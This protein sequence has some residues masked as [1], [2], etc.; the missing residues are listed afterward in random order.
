MNAFD[1][2]QEFDERTKKR[3]KN[4]IKILHYFQKKKHTYYLILSYNKAKSIKILN[5]DDV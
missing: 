4:Q 3:K 1:L 5:D 2:F